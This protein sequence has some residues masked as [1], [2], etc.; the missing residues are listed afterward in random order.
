MNKRKVIDVYR[1]MLNRA[2]TMRN[3]KEKDF[4][5]AGNEL[6]YWVAELEKTEEINPTKEVK[7]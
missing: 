1:D 3:M 7:R 6:F 4:Q 2:N 5:F